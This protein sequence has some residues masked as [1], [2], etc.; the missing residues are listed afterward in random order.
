ML[1]QGD[2]LDGKYK[3]LEK[4]G[5]GGMSKVYLAID[6]ALNKQWAVKEIDK[7]TEKYK[8]T[9][10]ENKTKS[11][12]EIMK[13]LSH[14]SLPRIVSIIDS[15]ES[16]CVVMDYIEGESL[17]KVISMYG[18]QDEKRVV[19]W[20]L[21]I[22][23]IINYLHHQDPPIIYRDMKPSNVMLSQEG[24]IKIID[25]GIAREFK[26]GRNDTAALGTMGYASPEHFAKRTD[27][28]SDIYS[29][30]A[31]MYTLLTG[32]DPS[33]DPPHHLQKLRAVDPTFSTGLE[34]VITK[35]TQLDPNNRYQSIQEFA[36]ALSSYRQLDDSYI[37]SLRKKKSSF[38]KKLILSTVTLVT[39][40]LLVIS[41]T[42]LESR[43]YESLL[44]SNTLDPNKRAEELQKAIML[45]PSN[46]DAYLE[47]IKVYAKDGQFTEVEAS[48]FLEVYS[49]CKDKISRN[50]DDYASLN[51]S[52][53]EAFL[54][55]YTGSND[56]SPRAKLLEAEPYFKVAASNKSFSKSTLASGYIFMADYYKTYV[57][58]DD[59]LVA[60][61]ATKADYK[62]LLEKSELVL[63]EVNSYK[64]S[65]KDKISI[66]TS[67]IILNLLDTQRNEMAKAGIPK[68]SITSLVS[69]IEK[70]LN[71]ID[72]NDEAK[73]S[74]LNMIT[75]V[76]QGLDL[77]YQVKKEEG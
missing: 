38:R 53:G 77:S 56:N 46:E 26:S 43:N 11:E 9:V 1:K 29:I 18:R 36:N 24:N 63:S 66:I 32:L 8:L 35:A 33:K 45:K 51:Y 28:R 23:D 34:K 30:G 13:K 44:N 64:G 62:K 15:D 67:Q 10:N 59:S 65:G 76:N 4:I 55:Y 68:S 74:A 41:G 31:T 27:I 14:P 48:N 61:D 73:E 39:G 22:C 5:Q 72:G 2:I 42:F 49:S 40:I 12:I 19:S 52:V 70:E 3:I 54:K 37:R 71:S 25:F 21:D 16:L 57:L 60:E 20:T 17:D 75:N 69:K 6:T 47:L 50:K 7:R 58:A